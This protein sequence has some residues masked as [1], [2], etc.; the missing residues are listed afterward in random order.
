MDGCMTDCRLKVCYRYFLAALFVAILLCQGRAIALEPAPENHSGA[1]ESQPLIAVIIDDLG[2]Q[3]LPGLRTIALDGPIACAIMPFTAHATYLAEQA[4]AAGKEVILHLPMQPVEMERIAG[5]GEISLDTD[6]AELAYILDQNLGSVP[7]SVGI[8]NHMGSL[9]TRHP[10][11]MR[12]LMQELAS[13]G[14]LFFI[15][16]FTTPDSVAYEI[17]IETGI[18][19]ARRHIFLDN[20]PTDVAIDNQFEHLKKRARR[21]GY[22]IGIGHPYPATLDYLQTALPELEK[23]GF[24]LVPVA[25]ITALL[26]SMNGQSKRANQSTSNPN[27]L[28]QAN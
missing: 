17:A 24:Q 1:V 12:W 6:K 7:H 25:Q 22:A 15:D 14:D 10:G 5:P 4:F 26:G 2:N 8:S 16:S 18:P 21:Y 19:A 28:V 27:I 20:E 9:I 13:R 3:R 11:H 23:Q